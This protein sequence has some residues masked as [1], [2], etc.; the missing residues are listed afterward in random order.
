MTPIGALMRGVWPVRTAIS[1]L[2]ARITRADRAPVPAVSTIEE[3]AALCRELS[4]AYRA[5]PVIDYSEHPERVEFYRLRGQLARLPGLDCDDLAFYASVCLRRI[6]TVARV[7]VLVDETGRYAHAVCEAWV[8]GRRWVLDT[9]GLAELAPATP[10][11]L[12]FA[13]LYPDARYVEEFV[14]PYPFVGQ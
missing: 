14:V 10:V 11:H 9:N 3:A 4:I 13:A 5:D 12:R 7:V 8:G 2:W 6:A 1:L